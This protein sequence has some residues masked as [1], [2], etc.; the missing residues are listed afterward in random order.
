M[1]APAA[2]PPKH[3]RVLPQPEPVLERDL[4]P[5]ERGFDFDLEDEADLAAEEE[6]DELPLRRPPA[7]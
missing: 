6:E 3:V 7:R 5:W 2:E 1:P 4:D